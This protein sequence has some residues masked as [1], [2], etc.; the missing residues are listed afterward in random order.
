MKNILV[1]TDFSQCAA[2]AYN[3]A[4]LL[5]EKTGAVIHLFHTLDIPSS[6]QATTGK[7]TTATTGDVQYMM[8]LMKLTKNRMKKTRNN[9]V[10]KDLRINEIIAI[11]NI[12][13][14]ISAA[15][16]QY[17]IDLIVMGTHGLSGMQ[18]NII[19]SNSE[20]VV[21]NAD[22]PVLTVKDSIKEPKIKKIL[23]G[24]DFSGETKH[25]LRAVSNITK[26]FGAELI[27][28][29]VV[30]LND[31]ESTHETEEQINEFRKKSKLFNYTTKIYYAHSRE[32]GIRNV[33][34]TLK[35][36][37]IAM[38]THGRHGLARLFQGSVAEEVVSHSA[39]PVLTINL[40]KKLMGA[41]VNKE[42]K[43]K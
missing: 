23:F 18:G 6:I 38:G 41:A 13:G 11:G 5:A 7:D 2:N 34:E 1:P 12:T 10:F 43:R 20:K 26:I 21:R 14:K 39:L 42:K 33:A 16:K 40:Q 30:T 4:A 17:K 37:I 3:Y 19:G 36:D 22:I 25:V 31:F 35:A 9:K 27:L 8:G 32:E 28:A 24:T 29:K 15:V